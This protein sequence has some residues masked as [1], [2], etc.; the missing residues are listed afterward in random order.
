MGG[1]NVND[2]ILTCYSKPLNML[3]DKAFT[4][5]FVCSNLILMFVQPLQ[6]QQVA[7]KDISENGERRSS[8]VSAGKS[9]SLIPIYLYLMV[10]VFIQNLN[11]CTHPVF[12]L[13]LSS[14]SI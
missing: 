10:V 6:G 12:H 9:I 8:V 5:R 2:Q 13:F 11:L 14:Y 1:K 4:T 7:E 3:L